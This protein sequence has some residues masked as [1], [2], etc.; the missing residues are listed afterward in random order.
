MKIQ[1]KPKLKSLSKALIVAGIVGGM[2]M[3]AMAK[4]YRHHDRG[5]DRGGYD[6]AKVVDVA[7]IVES[8]KVNN[9]VEQC[10]DEKVPTRPRHDRYRRNASSPTGE[11]L[12]AIIGGALG[13]Q[14]GSG[15]GKK[16]A[17]AAGAVLGASVAHDIERNQRNRHGYSSRGY[18]G[19][20]RYEVVQRCEIRDA[21]S[22]EEQVVGYDVAY[23]Y[24]GNIYHTQM[25]RHPG[26]KIRVRVS[27]DPV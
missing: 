4:D 5:Y 23:S 7:P 21:Y 18:D 17:T 27:V 14:F 13:N 8:Y 26:K 22:Y 1:S 12:G 25:D 19:Y 10:W 11:I 3:P 24:R 9:P 2:S 16:V 6:Y 15:R 20:D